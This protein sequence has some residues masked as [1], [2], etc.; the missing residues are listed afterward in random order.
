MEYLSGLTNSGEPVVKYIHVVFHMYPLPYNHN[1]FFVTQLVPFVYD[2]RGETEDVL[3]FSKFILENQWQF[4]SQA[5]NLTEFE[6]QY[7]I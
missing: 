5:Q 4:R 3:T 1:S 2:I 7:N 6:V